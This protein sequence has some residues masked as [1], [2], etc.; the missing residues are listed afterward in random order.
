[1]V[2][3]HLV[4]PFLD[5]RQGWC[6]GYRLRGR[7]P[8]IT[9]FQCTLRVLESL[10]ALSQ[11]VMLLCEVCAVITRYMIFPHDAMICKFTPCFEILTPLESARNIDEVG[12]GC[13]EI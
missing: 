13:S 8:R 1:M 9:P 3:G 2:E 7:I 12:L 6:Q 5:R 4:P 11:M 10:S